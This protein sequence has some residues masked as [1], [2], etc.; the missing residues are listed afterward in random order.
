MGAASMRSES[1]ERVLFIGGSQ[2]TGGNLLAAC[3]DG[4]PSIKAIPG[5]FRVPWRGAISAR[6]FENASAEELYRQIVKP[7]IQ[8][9]VHEGAY[10]DS[11]KGYRFD[12]ADFQQRIL[13]RLESGELDHASC[14]YWLAQTW[15]DCCPEFVE[16]SSEYLVIH[17][18]AFAYDIEGMIGAGVGQYLYTRRKALSWLAS[19]LKKIEKQR[20]RRLGIP[21]RIAAYVEA[22]EI[23]TLLFLKTLN[24]QRAEHYAR[25]YPDRVVI[26]DFE[27]LVAQPA[28]ALESSLR[29]LGLV[30]HD[31]IVATT[32]FDGA[33]AQSANT[34]YGP[35]EAPGAASSVARFLDE[36]PTEFCEWIETSIRA[37]DSVKFQGDEFFGTQ[38][39]E[40]SFALVR[41]VTRNINLRI[42]DDYR[43]NFFAD[44]VGVWGKVKLRILSAL[45]ER[46]RR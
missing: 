25:R 43:R 15:V 12:F 3:L 42:R 33:R 1:N 4:H 29:L 37:M 7:R 39:H 32:H 5:D 13:A 19:F 24:D 16:K 23:H 14:L 10:I 2:R 38:F 17:G 26:V 28:Q 44:S 45:T 20:I 30:P 36:S 41:Q 9:S 8:Q 6:R 46:Q 31:G 27:D 11:L 21:R 22:H 34:S 40:W 35:G 18:G